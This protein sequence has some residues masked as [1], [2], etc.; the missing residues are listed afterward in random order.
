MLR[1]DDKPA[2]LLIFAQGCAGN[3][4]GFPLRGGSGAADAAGLSLAFAASHALAE[5]ENV[6][7]ASLKARSLKLSLSLRVPSAAEREEWW[8][9][10]PGD[11]SISALLET[12]GNGEPQFLLFPMRVLAVGDELCIV[13]LPLYTFAEYQL[14]PVVRGRG[15]S[16][17]AHACLWLYQRYWLYVATKEADIV[18]YRT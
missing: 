13:T 17:C 4:N 9:E 14:L 8:A 16:V 10:N 6:T 11:E 1:T 5:S 2:G 12:D 3:I 7:P 18:V 15:V